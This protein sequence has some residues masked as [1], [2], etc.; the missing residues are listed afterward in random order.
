MGFFSRL[1]HRRGRPRFLVIRKRPVVLEPRAE[2]RG[3]RLEENYMDCQ[4]HYAA[5]PQEG[6]VSTSTID[7]TSSFT[8]VAITCAASCASSRLLTESAISS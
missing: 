3:K 7:G 8:A 1:N 4:P 2:V 6:P 5:S